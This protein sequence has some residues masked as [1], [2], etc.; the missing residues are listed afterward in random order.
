MH[1][2]S[3]TFNCSGNIAWI[4][5]LSTGL[6]RNRSGIWDRRTIY[7]HSDRNFSPAHTASSKKDVL[8]F[9]SNPPPALSLC[10][11]VIDCKVWNGKCWQLRELSY[12]IILF[13]TNSNYFFSK[14]N[15]SVGSWEKERGA[16][17]HTGSVRHWVQLQVT[18][19][20]KVSSSVIRRHT[21]G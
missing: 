19:T 6:S 5:S 21:F 20:H 1:G 15:S 4:L 18:Q 9:P 13:Y 12:L 8:I 2:L 17:P 7:P 14:N 11:S 10:C 16:E 3:L